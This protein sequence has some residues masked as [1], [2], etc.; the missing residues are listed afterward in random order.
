MLKK[1]LCKKCRNKFRIR[2]WTGYDE[3]RWKKG[4]VLCP[5]FIKISIK[6]K[7]K[8]RPPDLCWFFLEQ[9]LSNEDK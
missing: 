2:G 3:I 8:D 4:D 6:N 5:F 9:I 1:K 7:I